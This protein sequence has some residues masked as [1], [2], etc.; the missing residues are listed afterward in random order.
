MRKHMEKRHNWQFESMPPV[1]PDRR[2]SAAP[3]PN[4][5]ACLGSPV[6]IR[7]LVNF[8]VKH[9]VSFT[10]VCTHSFRLLIKACNPK[11]RVPSR[12]TLR[13]WL[14][15][16]HEEAL[17][18]VKKVFQQ[19]RCGK[20]A[21][22]LDL[23]TSAAGKG[24]LAIWGRYADKDGG[25]A[26]VLV[27]FGRMPY[28]H[29]ADDLRRDIQAACHRLDIPLEQVS[30]ITGDRAPNNE[31][32]MTKFKND[33]I[34][35]EWVPCL[36][37]LNHHAVMDGVTQSEGLNDSFTNVKF[38]AQSLNNSPK[39]REGFQCRVNEVN[40]NQPAGNRAMKR[41]CLARPVAN[42]WHSYDAMVVSALLLR[43]PMEVFIDSICRTMQSRN[44]YTLTRSQAV[45]HRYVCVCAWTSVYMLMCVCVRACT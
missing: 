29:G 32:M 2:K 5:Y 10:T 3:R 38:W 40:A 19:E 34:D 9:N 33:G 7:R 11:M 30:A 21:F 35:I 36:E 26:R 17:Q 42:R 6:F 20:T 16:F 43:P 39:L 28:P 14:Q 18:E 15:K 25:L 1:A 23:W 44:P 8:C 27:Y 37:H 12:H 41:V 4:R 45:K 22:Q 24:F 31:S 13:S